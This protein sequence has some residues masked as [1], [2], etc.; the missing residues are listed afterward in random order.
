MIEVIVFYGMCGEC[1][2][3]LQAQERELT[4]WTL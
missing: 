4:L 2:E 3:T 1:K